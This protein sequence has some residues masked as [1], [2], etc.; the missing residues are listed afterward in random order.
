MIA[1]LS[2][3]KEVVFV[4]R[5]MDC[6][7]EERIIRNGLAKVEGI[8][9]LRFNLMQRELTVSHHLA[10]DNLVFSLL[11]DLKM[12]PSRKGDGSVAPGD[13]EGA[14]SLRSKILVGFSGVAAISAETV[15]WALDNE[16]SVFVIGFSLLAIAAGGVETFKKGIVALRT[17]TLNINFLMMIAIAG[18]SLIGA[19]PEAA[20]VTFL[21]ALAEM[22]EAYSLDRA[23]QAIRGLME[24]TPQ[25]AMTKQSDGSWKE[26]AVTEVAL[27]SI[28]LVKPGERIPLDG[29]IT[30]GEPSI[31]QAPITGESMPVDK[32]IGDTVF[33]GTINERSTFEFQVT[34]NKGDTTLARIIRSVQ[35]AQG[36]RA[37]RHLCQ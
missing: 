34:A 25:S 15:G 13:H 29:L 11:Q 14:V 33:A 36:E 7:T 27:N 28:I 26:V 3:T 35:A 10:D 21:F 23:R 37:P 20:M 30:T 24:M 18:A 22:I 9:D 17:L 2:Q 32:R 19:W 8:E 16:Q 12:D 5:N 4:V 1:G 31:N 6:P